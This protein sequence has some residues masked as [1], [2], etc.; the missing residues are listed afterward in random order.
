MYQMRKRGA[1]AEKKHWQ[2]MLLRPRLC[3]RGRCVQGTS[4]DSSWQ[5]SRNILYRTCGDTGFP[6]LGLITAFNCSLAQRSPLRPVVHKAFKVVCEGRAAITKRQ[7]ECVCVSGG[8]DT[9][10]S[11]LPERAKHHTHAYVC[12]RTQSGKQQ[13]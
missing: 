10:K 5:S 11:D 3:E 2:D 9:S 8:A 7:Q 12:V 1:A 13:T 6:V 4:E